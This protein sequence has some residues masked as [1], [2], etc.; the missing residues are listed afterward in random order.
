M[1]KISYYI[2][3]F[4]YVAAYRVYVYILYLLQG[5]RSN[6]LPARDITYTRTHTQ[7]MLLHHRNIKYNN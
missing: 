5:G 1:L 2:L 3:C 7:Y 6:D 4:G